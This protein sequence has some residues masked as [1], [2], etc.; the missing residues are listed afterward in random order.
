MKV[1]F[2]HTAAGHVDL[3]D[4]LLQQLDDTATALHR[5]DEGLLEAV[6]RGEPSDQVG[7][8]LAQPLRSLADAGCAAL[9]C[10]CSTLGA[11]AEGQV[12]NGLVVQRIDRAAADY[13]VPRPRV[14]VLAALAS[15]GE[16]AD[17]LLEQSARRQG[18]DSGWLVALV[19]GAWQAFLKADIAGYHEQIANFANE[20]SDEY[21][22][23]F[24]AQASMA[25]AAS[26]CRHQDVVTS[27]ERGVRRLLGLD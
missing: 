19:P 1:G 23:L 6:S 21:D 10:T 15:A 13:L 17:A 2:L 25:G 14:L 22:A 11:M 20:F 12:F 5:I 16:A 8:M 4:G 7:L 3:F 18:S 27:P 24:L 26:A 9:A